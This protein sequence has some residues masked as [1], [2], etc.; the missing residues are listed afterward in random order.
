MTRNIPFLLLFAPAF[1]Q[2][3]A[4]DTVIRIRVNLVQ[5]DAVV[6]DSKDK[7]ATDLKAQDFEILQDG[8]A[9]VI[10]NFSYI[11]TAP[12]GPPVAPRAAQSK[13]GP[14]G[15]PPAVLKL[16]DVRRTV[17]LVVDDLGLSFESIARVRESL[18]RFVDEG[19]QPGDLVAVIRTGAGMG[20]LQRFTADNRLLHAAIDRVKYNSIGRVGVSSFTPL[21]QDEGFES[22]NQAREEI[23]SAGTLGAVRYVLDGLRELPGRKSVVL[24]SENIRLFS[25]EGLND[26]VMDAVRHLTDVANRSSVAIYSIDPRGLQ[27]YN[28]TAADNPRGMTPQQV[29]EAPLRRSE[30][31]LRSQDGLVMLARD[32]GG[33]FL[34]DTNDIDGA[35]RK[36]MDDG[37]SYYL[38]GYHPDAATFDQKTGRAKFHRVQ[39]RVKRP[40]LH[41]RSRSGF[42]GTTDRQQQPVAHTREAQ[43]AH[44]FTSPFASGAIHVR[45]TTLFS[46]APQ[47]GAFLSGLLYIDGQDLEFTD[48]PDDWHKA[49]IDVVAVTFG[50]NGQSVDSSDRT[51]TIRLRGQ[52]Y[53]TVLA[54]GLIYSMHHPVKKPGAYQMRVALRDAGSAQVGSASQFVE[55]PDV[56]KG[57]LTLSSVVLKEAGAAAAPVA[58]DHPEGQVNEPNPSGSVAVRIFKP[59]ASLMYGY[60][61]L[62]AETNSAKQPELEAQTRLFRDGKQVYAGKPNEVSAAEQP[63]PKR[64]IAGGVMRLGAKMDP[65]DYVLQVIVTDKL[66]KEKYRTATQWMDFEVR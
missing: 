29:S 1:A 49:V 7:P 21:G 25:A 65:G 19:M 57:R 17:A 56:S 33:L 24:F 12:A 58:P 60:Q 13:T 41:V 4:P 45:L 63:D 31:A 54:Q 40:G 2:V 51:Y 55:V 66:A 64:L 46:S 30:Q 50:D 14:P 36:V 11:S 5:V 10:T 62:N 42:F 32:T 34:Y 3:P 20:A 9:Q 39:V 38:I 26:R 8:K 53:R 37:Q 27:T 22:F 28:L 61:I 47:S 35:L 16:T 18:K 6:T 43:L 15:P 59:G 52:T 44:A 48:E 23:F